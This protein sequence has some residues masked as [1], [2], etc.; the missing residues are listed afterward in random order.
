MLV[1]IYYWVD[2]RIV[3]RTVA[4]K[5]QSHCNPGRRLARFSENYRH[6]KIWN[7]ETKQCTGQ[8]RK[9]DEGDAKLSPKSLTFVTNM[10]VSGSFIPTRNS[11]SN[12]RAAIGKV[13]CD[14]ATKC[15]PSSATLV[16]AWS[17]FQFIT[18]GALPWR[19]SFLW[20]SFWKSQWGC[21]ANSNYSFE[22][23]IPASQIVHVL[24]RNNPNKSFNSPR[25]NFRTECGQ[26][27]SLA[28]KSSKMKEDLETNKVLLAEKDDQIADLLAG[29][30]CSNL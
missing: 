23:A 20:I 7:S 6:S 10:T 13:R 22:V 29:N 18:N 11:N 16:Y 19:R 1:W 28:W 14:Q 5:E 8:S 21:S 25:P 9:G 30:D 15:V 2:E 26:C 24:A 3:R 27:Q 17:S 4:P 12:S